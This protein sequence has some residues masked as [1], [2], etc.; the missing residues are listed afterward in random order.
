MRK[1]IG[2][3]FGQRLA[4]ALMVGL[5]IGFSPVVFISGQAFANG[6][7]DFTNNTPTGDPA[8]WGADEWK[9]Q[10]QL[11]QIN[12][13]LEYATSG[14]GTTKD[15]RD[16]KWIATQFP[17]SG[18]WSIE[19]SVVNKTT[20]TVNG[21]FS[22]FGINIRNPDETKE[23]EVEHAASMFD[24]TGSLYC[25]SE[26]HT[27]QMSFTLVCSILFLTRQSGLVLMALRKSSLS[28]V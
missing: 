17:Y 16:R 26:L 7:D 6:S 1:H 13:R 4:I 9:G 23:I 21:D 20:P 8:K 22:S 24:N 2:I 14:N 28:R 10:G 12:G 5:M 27:D 11:S 18:N 3:M 19:L 15:S 25:H